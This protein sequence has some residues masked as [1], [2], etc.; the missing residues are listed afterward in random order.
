M[1]KIGYRFKQETLSYDKIELTLRKRLWTL[2]K[3]SFSSLC[4]G[5][6]LFLKVSAMLDSPNQKVLKRENEEILAQYRLIN[7]ELDK[8]DQVLKNLEGRDENIYRTI[9]EANPIDPSIRRA[10]SGGVNRYEHLKNL[11]ESDFI[12]S[13]TRKLDELS[14]ALYIQSKSYDE[15]EKMVKEMADKLASIPAILPVSIT[16]KTYT[17]SGYGVRVHPILKHRKMHNGQDFSTPIGTPIYATGDGVVESV[18]T[19]GGFGQQITINHGFK[20]S[21]IYAHLSK[22][23]VHKGQKVKRGELIGYSGNSGLSSGPHLHYEVRKDGIPQNPINFFFNELTPDEYEIMVA[24]ANNH[25][26][27]MD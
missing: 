1:R 23:N 17:S 20:Y 18:G 16:E 25:G 26:Q 13:T 15:V 10:G 2:L 11:K 27:S 21:T 12:V 5:I 24:E 14:K 19:N 22:Y 9:F 6:I 3:K 4:I 7:H 8:L